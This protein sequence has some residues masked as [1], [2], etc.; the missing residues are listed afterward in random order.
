M[1]RLFSFTS[2]KAFSNYCKLSY[3]AWWYCHSSKR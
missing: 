3:T 1:I 2:E